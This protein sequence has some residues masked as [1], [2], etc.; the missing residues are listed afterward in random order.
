MR[1]IKLFEN[2]QM[3]EDP[4]WLSLGTFVICDA[5]DPVG[6]YGIGSILIYEDLPEYINCIGQI[7]DIGRVYYTVQYGTSKKLGKQREIGQ[8][9]HY[10]KPNEIYFWNKDFKEC[11]LYVDATKYN[12]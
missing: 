10:A 12:L 1:Y 9:T 11:M 6:D 5:L 7:V 2:S 3:E 4:G 8:Y